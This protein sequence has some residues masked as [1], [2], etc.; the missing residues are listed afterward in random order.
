MKIAMLGVDGGELGSKHHSITY[1]ID[2]KLAIDAGG[3][4]H[5]M[6][7]D[8]LLKIDSLLISHTHIDHV[9]DMMFWGDLIF[10]QRPSI[11][12]HGAEDV[13]E[14]IKKHLFNWVIWPD[15]SSIP[16]KDNP[17]FKFIPHKRGDSFEIDGGYKIKSVEVNHTVPSSAFFVEKD[18][19]SILYSSDTTTTDK[20]WEEAN[21]D[22]NLKV[23]FMEISFSNKL[24]A[25]ADASKHYSP[26]TL[27]VDLQKIKKD[28]PIYLY[29][30]KP[31][32]YDEV[33]KEVKKLK[34]DRLIF[35]SNKKIIEI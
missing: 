31:S 9:K 1:L 33:V 21:N 25:V 30:I 23:I 19:K 24:Q 3:L 22:D 14:S 7:M 11:K 6:D 17:V 12:V 20:V 35:A 18:S 2:D 5:A 32:V 15:F 4:L 8:S 10:G 34:D 27:A 16:T 13:L 26:A 29:H 28:I